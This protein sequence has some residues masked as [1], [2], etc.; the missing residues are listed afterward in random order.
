[1]AGT[2]LFPN[3]TQF[4]QV[5]SQAWHGAGA[6]PSAE[7][8]GIS[9]NR[10]AMLDRL[11]DDEALGLKVSMSVEIPD[12]ISW[13]QPIR[14]AHGDILPLCA[15]G[16]NESV[17]CPHHDD[18]PPI[19][20]TLAS[21]ERGAD[22]IYCPVCDRAFWA[23]A[24]SYFAEEMPTCQPTGKGPDHFPVLHACG[25]APDEQRKTDVILARNDWGE[26]TYFMRELEDLCQTEQ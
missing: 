6:R 13:E 16:E 8:I 14:G 26:L 1:M 11:S 22:G 10:L 23:V 3:S 20:V 7:K 19:A 24:R 15:Y 9:S 4:P 21:P 18:T 5:L 12:T 25:G 2:P 17:Y